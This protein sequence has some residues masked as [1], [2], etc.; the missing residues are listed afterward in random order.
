MAASGAADCTADLRGIQDCKEGQKVL[1]LSASCWLPVQQ[2]KLSS[3]AM[4]A[5]VMLP[6]PYVYPNFICACSASS[7]GIQVQVTLVAAKF[8]CHQIICQVHVPAWHGMS[9]ALH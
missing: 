3:L 8:A 1:M 9:M 7:V 4:L 2:R 6:M 5:V